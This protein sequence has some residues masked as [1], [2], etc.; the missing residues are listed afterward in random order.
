MEYIESL[1]LLI[2]EVRVRGVFA[3][4]FYHSMHRPGGKLVTGIT[5]GMI[6]SSFSRELPQGRRVD[7]DMQ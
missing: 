2:E 3:A 6:R 5:L 4:Y 7:S 1:F